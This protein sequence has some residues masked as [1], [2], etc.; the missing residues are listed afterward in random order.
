MVITGVSAH[1]GIE[2]ERGCSAVHE[3]AKQIVA[4]ESLHDPAAGVTVNVGQV[5][6]GT[7]PNVVAEEAR[8]MIDVRVRT[9]ADAARLQ[10]AIVE[11]SGIDRRAT[12]RTSGRFRPPMERTP[13]VERLYD[14]AKEVAAELGRELGEFAT[15]GGSDGN[16][17]A[18]RGIPTLDGLGAVGEGAH[19]LQE[20][21]DLSA[22][23]WRAALLAGL[24]GRLADGRDDG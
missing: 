11:R 12:V 15:G 16:L 18:A 4:L 3:M 13:A 20:Q 5:R 8:A 19:A 21:I 2:P 22:L 10:Q 9:A 6:G 17:T 14:Q 1:A 24:I 23:P 7:R